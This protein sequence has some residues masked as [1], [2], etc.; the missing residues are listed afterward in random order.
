MAYTAVSV[1]EVRAW[2][3][4][5]GAIALD[6]G[7]EYFAFEYDPDWVEGGIELAPLSTPLT[8]RVQVY[9]GLPE[10]TYHR[11]PP[12]VADALPDDFGNAL[13]TAYLASQ[14]VERRSIT[15]LD[16]LAYL[17]RRGMGALEFRPTR[18]PQRRKPTAL[19]LSEL[20]L[21]ARGALSGRIEGDRESAAALANLIQ[22]GT[23]AGGARAKAIIAWNP[24][25]GEVR[26]GQLPAEEGFEQ[27]MIKLDGVGRDTE[28]GSS[29]GYGRIEYAYYLMAT[30][31]G[32]EMSPSRLLEEN[33]RAHFMTKRFDRV[34]GDAAHEKIHLQ[35][36][37]AMA[38]LDY[39]QRA[40]HDY[41]QYFQ[42]I[43]NL[44]LGDDARTEAFRRMVF[45]VMARNCDDHTK[46]FSFLLDPPVSGGGWR[47]APAYDVTYAFNPAGRWTYQ[48][49]MSVNGSFGEIT[50]E[51]LLVVADRFQVPHRF[52]VISQVSETV[53]QWAGFADQAGIPA[54]EV[55][56]IRETFP[57]M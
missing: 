38:E 50:R 37:C 1:I 54:G 56:R 11:L 22:V 25:T 36:L 47:L 19:E 16:R 8:E 23:S 14:G 5:V 41:A 13:V 49:L 18:G 10:P 20:V 6:P 4:L 9:P 44:G 40:T 31:A 3:R 21:G 48:H 34:G 30:A 53:A 46:N 26:S 42:A 33:G 15:A 27:W 17:G 43:G 51:D 45:N 28:L 55:A 39:K 32:I 24:A 52:D 35:T 12:F 2:D 57:A 7:S 29:A